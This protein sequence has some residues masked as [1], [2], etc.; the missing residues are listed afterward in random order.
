MTRYY[1]RLPKTEDARDF[2][3]I[4]RAPHT[5]AFVDL[6]GNF[7]DAPYDQGSLGSCVSNGV[8][9]A[10]DFARVK[11][12]ADPYDSPSRLFIY[13]NGRVLAGDP[14]DQD[15]GLQIRDGFKAVATYGAPREIEWP[16][17]VARFADKPT[18]LTYLDALKDEAGIY[19]AVEQGSIDAMIAS[20]YP[21][22]FGFDVYDS[23]ESAKTAS[24]GIMSVPDLATER[25]LGGHCVV[26]VST[27]RDGSLCGGEP[28]VLYRK[29]RNSWGTGWGQSG[30]FWM[31]VE[32]MDGS[33]CSDFWQVTTT[34][35]A[36]APTPPAP[37]PTPVPTPAGCGWLS[38]IL[39][40]LGL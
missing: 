37:S 34:K 8:A 39:R 20:G 15:T 2:K 14:I 6:S 9:A 11:S 38:K 13:Y 19:G 30:H 1:G 21:V 28:G 22:V 35:D 31:P 17:N 24:T 26:A 23:F 5:G 40:A 18:N 12:H 7:P 16:Y 3:A 33:E 10:L 29:C 4:P 25:L 32:V 36:S 27:P